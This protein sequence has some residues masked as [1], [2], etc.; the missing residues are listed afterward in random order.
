LRFCHIEI[1]DQQA[2]IPRHGFTNSLV[3]ITDTPAWPQSLD[4]IGLPKMADRP[5]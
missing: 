5:L 3:K 2:L 4:S 1:I